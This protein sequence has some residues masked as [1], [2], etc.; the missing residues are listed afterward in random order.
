MIDF[1]EN[2][3]GIIGTVE[4]VQGTWTRLERFILGGGVTGCVTVYGVDSLHI[5][6]C[7]MRR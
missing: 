6:W 5:R 2:S 3:Y 4:G 7:S 1:S